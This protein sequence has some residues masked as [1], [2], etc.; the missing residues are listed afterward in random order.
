[1]GAMGDDRARALKAK[2]GKIRAA[3][4]QKPQTLA[5][6]RDSLIADVVSRLVTKKAKLDV[7]GPKMMYAAALTLAQAAL[8]G[9]GEAAGQGQVTGQGAKPAS[10]NPPRP[11]PEQPPV[12]PQPPR[13][14][15]TIIDAEY[16]VLG[17]PEV[18][19]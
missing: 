17:P 19:P 13:P 1:M 8:V 2:R 11:R 15:P 14:R 5:S 9:L 3:P 12:V 10:T 18:L 6:L 4:A 7:E 16:T